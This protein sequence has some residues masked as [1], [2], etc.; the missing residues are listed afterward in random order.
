MYSSP[1]IISDNFRNS[2]WTGHV[3]RMGDKKSQNILVENPKGKTQ[4]GISTHRLEDNIK[5]LCRRLD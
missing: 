4:F 5:V 1:N 2:R 3:A